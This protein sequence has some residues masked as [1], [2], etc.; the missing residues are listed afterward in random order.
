MTSFKGKGAV[1]GD[2]HFDQST[3][4]QVR[5]A[6]AFVV[7]EIVRQG[8]RWAVFLGDLGIR[9]GYISPEF[10]TVIRTEIHRLIKASCQAYL[11]VGNHDMSNQGDRAD[12]ISAVFSVKRGDAFH[13]GV[14]GVEVI[15][16]PI[17]AKLGGLTL[18]FMPYP[19]KYNLVGL[20]LNRDDQA[21]IADP[22]A[23]MNSLIPSILQGLGAQVGDDLGILFSHAGIVGGKA[24]SEVD[25]PAGR[26]F[27]INWRD[28]PAAFA[29]TFNGHLHARQEVGPVVMPGCIADLNHYP[30]RQDHSFLIL[31]IDPDV[32]QQKFA[33]TVVPIPAVHSLIA[34]K[35][36]DAD[37][38][39]DDADPTA[40]ALK[41]IQAETKVVDDVKVFLPGVEGEAG[42]DQRR[43]DSERAVRLLRRL[44][45]FRSERRR[46]RAG[47]GDQPGRQ[48][49]RPASGL[50]GRRREDAPGSR[51][52]GGAGRGDR[53]EDPGRSV[54]GGPPA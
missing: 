18:G 2:V 16:A 10:A 26:E 6:L 46:R 13:S 41:R 5:P 53:S 30:K 37:P 38:I 49:G 11:L 36:E 22:V 47:R 19:S 34:V 32:D 43:D 7:D 15:T 24:D 21:T 17:V 28:I 42:S 1:V 14:A 52:A 33:T 40:A 39:W 4:A 50:G 35:F 12:N 44:R 9:R 51:P 45:P 54:A 27:E 31:D 8:C 20:A 29:A 23:A 48:P 25:M 3:A